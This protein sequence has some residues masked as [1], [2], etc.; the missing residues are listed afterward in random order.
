MTDLDSR[1]LRYT[2]CYGQKFNTSG[3]H[4][5]R[6]R[7]A[8]GFSVPGDGD[9]EYEI[10]V[11]GKKGSE[12]RQHHVK[13]SMR[14]GHLAAEPARLEIAPGDVVTWASEGGTTGFVVEGGSEQFRFSSAELGNQSVYMH[15]FGLPGI[16]RWSDAHEGR[17]SGEVEVLDVRPAKQADFDRWLKNL[18]QGSLV[19]IKGNSVNPPS[20]KIPVGGT[21]FWAIEGD[22]SISVTDIR[23][24]Q[25][26]SPP[27]DGSC[28]PEQSAG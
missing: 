7:I 15:A 12:P 22:A 6:L 2:D 9:Q 4:R 24:L 13:V 27:S 25:T 17:V 28:Q 14:D 16:F 19:H 20:V 11:A 21:V 5:Y 23:L 3:S 18:E 1:I 8:A 26:K 10:Q